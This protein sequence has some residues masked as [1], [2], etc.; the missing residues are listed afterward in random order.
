MTN[1][2]ALDRSFV[3]SWL[4]GGLFAGGFAAWGCAQSQP[5][6]AAPAASVATLPTPRASTQPSAAPATLDYESIVAAPD[7]SPEDRALDAGRHPRELLALIAVRPGQK[8]A[9]L[10]AGGGYTSELLARAVGPGGV[11][12]AQNSKFILD[13]FAEKPWSLRLQ[14]PV[15]KNVVRVDREFDDPLPPEASALDAVINVLF[16]HDT[17][18]LKTDRV[19][20]NQAIFRALKPGGVYVVLDHSAGPGS[21]LADVE[22]LHRIDEQ[23]V[24]SEIEQAGFRLARES[25]AWRAPDDT[26]D[27]SASPRF[28]GERRGT[29]DRFAVAYVKP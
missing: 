14:K 13:R 7:R 15:M 10:G 16:Y 24:R 22:T 29:S 4:V 25:S 23:A 11:V 5:P 18:W 27:W 8:V 20:M 1:P 2:S 12:Y 9:E 28:A 6:S 19:R 3:T 17:V 21:G 26:R